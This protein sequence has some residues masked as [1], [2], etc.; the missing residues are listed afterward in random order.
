MDKIVD[1]FI[2]ELPSLN[3]ANRPSRWAIIKEKKRWADLVQVYTKK[4]RKP[5]EVALVTLRRCSTREPDHDNLVISFKYILDAIVNRG[6]LE[7]DKTKNFK[8]GKPDY[9]W[10]KVG[11]KEQGVH[12]EIWA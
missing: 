12:I 5:L 11:Q 8:Y 1:I 4:P 3:I 9:K 10:A 6:I 7:D 2:P